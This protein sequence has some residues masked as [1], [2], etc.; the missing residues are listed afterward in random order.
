MYNYQYTKNETGEISNRRLYKISRPAK[1]INVTALDLTA[2][3]DDSERENII[4]LYEEWLEQYQKPLDAKIKELRS[5][6]TTFK[7][8]AAKN[9]IALE[10]VPMVKTFTWEHLKPIT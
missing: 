10:K 1:N 9:G 5:E 2:F 8:Y 7:T 6:Q 4:K 3:D